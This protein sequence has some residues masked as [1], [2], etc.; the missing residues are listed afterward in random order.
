MAPSLL[1]SSF[2][3]VQQAMASSPRGNASSYLLFSFHPD[4]L[5]CRQEKHT[6]SRYQ[7]GRRNQMHE[8]WSLL[9]LETRPWR[10]Q[11]PKHDTFREVDWEG[12]PAYR[13][14]QERL[15]K[16]VAPRE[17]FF[18]R[19]VERVDLHPGRT[20]VFVSIGSSDYRTLGLS[21]T[22]TSLPRSI[23]PEDISGDRSTHVPEH[24]LIHLPSHA[25]TNGTLKYLPEK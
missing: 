11:E 3:A 7:D 21:D 24:T 23:G 15:F 9:V 4:V 18:T 2:R 20:C 14:V 10:F 1:R 13:T 5:A 6:W 8:P 17:A 25:N 19:S 16:P 22:D 12:T